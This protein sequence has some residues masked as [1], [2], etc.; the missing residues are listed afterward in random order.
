MQQNSTQSGT[1]YNKH[2][3]STS[4]TVTLWYY[5]FRMLQK[6]QELTIFKGILESIQSTNFKEN[7]QKTIS[8]AV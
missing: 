2:K 4:C 5:K 3:N 8:R 7:V 6:A 1:D